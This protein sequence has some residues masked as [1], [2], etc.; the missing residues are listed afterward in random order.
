VV[1]VFKEREIRVFLTIKVVIAA[2]KEFDKR[3]KEMG[4]GGGRG[5]TN[6]DNRKESRS[7][8]WKGEISVESSVDI[9]K[10]T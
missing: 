8:R 5:T 4:W 6:E 1:L 9:H 3:R 2:E 10:K 7:G